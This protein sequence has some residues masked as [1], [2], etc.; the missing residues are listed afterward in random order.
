MK[1]QFSNEQVILVSEED[2]ELGLMPKLEAHQKGLLHRAFSVFVFNTKGDLLL[3]QRASSKYHSPGLWSNTC[4]SHP[5]PGEQVHAAAARRLQEEMGMVCNLDQAF[6]FIY[7]AQVANN[8]IEHEYDYVF[9]GTADT[10]PNINKAEV[11]SWKYIS[12]EILSGD[13]NQFPENYTAWLKIVFDK[14]MNFRK[15]KNL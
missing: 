12:P 15:D 11:Q 7:R 14:V 5:R 1:D 9:F 8:L 10:V 4:C 2:A 13:I 6:H 3:Q